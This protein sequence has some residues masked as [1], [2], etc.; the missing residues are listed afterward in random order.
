MG[1]ELTKKQRTVLKGKVKKKILGYDDIEKKP[2]RKKPRV[3]RRERVV[4][5]RIEK[6]KVFRYRGRQKGKSTT[7]RKII[8]KNKQVRFIDAKGRYVSVKK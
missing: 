8:L 1:D 3:D 6:R 5:K 4:V 7:A 2:A